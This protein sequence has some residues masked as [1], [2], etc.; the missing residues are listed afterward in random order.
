M[1]PLRRVARPETDDDI[2]QTRLPLDCWYQIAR[3]IDSLHGSVSVRSDTIGERAVIDARNWTFARSI[4]WRDDDVIGV[5]EARNKLVEEI[6]DARIAMRLDDRDDATLGAAARRPEHGRDFGRVV[7]VVVVNRDAVP[8]ARQLEAPFDA[9]KSGHRR[10]DLRVFY[11]GFR[12]DCNRGERIERIM[13]ARQ[14]NGPAFEFA[15][16]ALDARRQA[17]VEVRRVALDAHR[18]QDEIAIRALTVS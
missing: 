1:R 17:R 14:R 4:E 15:R 5:F 3:R 12:R 9:G 13:R 6:T 8:F 7:A 18:L 11:P 16:P 2:A 10:F